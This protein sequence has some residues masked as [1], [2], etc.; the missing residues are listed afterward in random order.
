M[1]ELLCLPPPHPPQDKLWEEIIMKDVTV[2]ENSN[3]NVNHSF[4]VSSAENK[5]YFIVFICHI[6]KH[7]EAAKKMCNPVL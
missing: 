6:W 4:T 7:I 5:L 2:A 3:K 1:M